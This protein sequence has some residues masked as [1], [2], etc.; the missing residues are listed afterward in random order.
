[1]S[2]FGSIFGEDLIERE[3]TV[4]GKTITTHWRPLTAGQTLELLEG[5]VVNFEP[6]EPDDE[7]EPL[8]GKRSSGVRQA[9]TRI[10]LKDSRA[11]DLRRI[12]MSLC[13]ETGKPRFASLDDLKREPDYVIDA[14]VG[15]SRQVHTEDDAGN[16]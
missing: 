12:Q 7:A 2:Y 8:D 5:Q 6:V 9:L 15:L 11:R 1:M 4:R 3:L 14:L 13:D 16:D 10:V